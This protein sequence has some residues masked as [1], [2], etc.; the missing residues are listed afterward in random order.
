MNKKGQWNIGLGLALVL[1]GI[2]LLASKGT[3]GIILGIVLVGVGAW[4]IFK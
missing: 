2:F 4:L 1:G 3:G